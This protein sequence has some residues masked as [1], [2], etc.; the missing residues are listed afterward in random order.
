MIFQKIETREKKELFKME[1]EKEEERQS[2]GFYSEHV[3]SP[4]E[5]KNQTGIPI[6]DQLAANSD[7]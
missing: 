3:I 6:G 4:Q 1:S 7:A 5:V 2:D